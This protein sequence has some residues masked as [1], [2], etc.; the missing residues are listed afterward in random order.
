MAHAAHGPGADRPGLDD[1][2]RF[3]VFGNF[4]KSE[5]I[6]MILQGFGQH[7]AEVIHLDMQEGLARNF[8]E[9]FRNGTL[10]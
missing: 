4:L 5:T 1:N 8:L 7:G 10:A 3:S 2:Q 9:L 6:G